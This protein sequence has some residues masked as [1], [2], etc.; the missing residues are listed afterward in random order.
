[1]TDRAAATSSTRRTVGL[2]MAGLAIACAVISY[3]DGLFLVHRAGATGWVAWLYP[4][5]PDGLIVISVAS[6]YDASQS[7]ARRPRWATT[8]LAIGAVLTLAMN[9]A[10]GLA[11]TEMD[12]LVDGVVPVVF[13]VAV[14]ILNG[15]IRR[16]RGGDVDRPAAAACDH[17]LPPPPLTLDD[18]IRAAA[19]AGLSKR[20]IADVFECGRP[21]VDQV[22]PPVPKV[23]ELAAAGLNGSSA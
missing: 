9:V 21:R 11:H 20:R 2:T 19:E 22:L 23:P 15:L 4:L 8:G 18:A 14:E 17:E 13:F 16:G 6:L 12:A 10:A 3:T 7:R 1:M 5:L